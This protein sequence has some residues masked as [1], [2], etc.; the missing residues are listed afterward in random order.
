[1]KRYRL[2]EL[3]RRVLEEADVYPSIADGKKKTYVKIAEAV[4][5]FS[6]LDNVYYFKPAFYISTFLLAFSYVFL[7]MLNDVRP[8]IFYFLPPLGDLVLDIMWRVGNLL[9]IAGYFVLCFVILSQ[10]RRLGVGS[11]EVAALT[12]VASLPTLVLL[13]Y[14]FT[15]YYGFIPRIIPMNLAYVLAILWQ[16]LA[17]SAVLHVAGISFSRAMLPPLFL[18]YVSEAVE[19]LMG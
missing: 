7:M 6:F 14:S 17:Y 11:A 9:L 2:S 13:L 10:R 18:W 12:I 5:L 8:F 19:K 16:V 4:S 3:G 15:V 1:L